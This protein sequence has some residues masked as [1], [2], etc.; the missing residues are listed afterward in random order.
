MHIFILLIFL[1]INVLVRI[2]DFQN[3][4]IKGNIC[5]RTGGDEFVVIFSNKNKNQ[6]MDVINKKE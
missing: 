6:V 3:R 2:I 5:R 1:C 4:S